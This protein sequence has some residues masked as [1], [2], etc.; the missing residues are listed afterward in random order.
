MTYHESHLDTTWHYGHH[1]IYAVFEKKSVKVNQCN[2]LQHHKWACMY[3]GGIYLQHGNPYDYYLE[4]R[5]NSAWLPSIFLG[6]QLMFLLQYVTTK[7][8]TH[9]Q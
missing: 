9:H 8:Y 3:R 2:L 4:M 5:P 6:T 1:S 7:H